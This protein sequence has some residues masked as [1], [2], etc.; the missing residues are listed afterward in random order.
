MRKIRF[1]GMFLWYFGYLLGSAVT[2]QTENINFVIPD[3]QVSEN[4]GAAGPYQYHP[5]IASNHKGD[6]LLA[7][8]DA[9]EVNPSIYAQRFSR[10]GLLTGKNFRISDDNTF[11]LKEHPV[12]AMDSSGNFVIIWLDFRSNYY[13]I[14]AQTYTFEGNPLGTNIKVTDF[15]VPPRQPDV[16]IDANGNFVITWL[17]RRNASWDIYAQRYNFNGVRLGGNFRVNEDITAPHD[18]PSIS[19]AANGDFVIT[20]L[21]SLNGT[22]GIYAQ[23][24]TTDG[25]PTGTNFKVNNDSINSP[26]IFPDVSLASNGEFIIVWRDNSNGSHVYGQRFERNGIRVGNNFKVNDNR[27][28]LGQHSRN[29]VAID[30]SG[31]FVVVWDRS[32]PGIFDS[33]IYAQRYLNDGTPSGNNF[34]VNDDQ[35]QKQQK[36]P[37]IAVDGKGSVT[38]AWEDNRTHDPDVYI[39]SYT[40]EGLLLAENIRIN[41]DSLSNAGQQH[42]A[43]AVDS[44]GNFIITW[45]D[46]RN[47]PA[48]LYAQRYTVEGIPIGVNFKVNQDTG[49]YEYGLPSMAADAAGNFTVAW[50]DREH[51]SD[52]WE[53]VYIRRFSS[54]GI[55]LGENVRIN[56]FDGK[57]D[58]KN[59]P[60]IAMDNEGNFV[61]TWNYRM[62]GTYH[63]EIYAQYFSKTGIPL[64]DNFVVN[65]D[66]IEAI[67]RSPEVAMNENGD[68]V[69]AWTDT[70]DNDIIN[71]YAQRFASGGISLGSN[72]KVS[73]DMEGLSHFF[74]NVAI[75]DVGDFVVSWYGSTGQE[76]NVFAQVY[77]NDGS[78]IG[79][80][81]QVND[82]AILLDPHRRSPGI[83]FH[84]NNQFLITWETR[85]EASDILGQRYT[86]DG[87]PIGNNFI[88]TI[89]NERKQL[90]TDIKIWNNRIYHTWQDN[91]TPATGADIWANILDFENPLGLTGNAPASFPAASKLSQNF[92]N[93][94]NASTI[95][96]YELHEKSVVE[97]VVYNLI[98]QKVKTLLEKSKQPPGVYQLRWDGR[99]SDGE[100]VTSGL[101]FYQLKTSSYVKTQKMLMIK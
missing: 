30:D 37:D 55:A 22:P 49:I 33:N 81:F 74:P 70:R 95:I 78:K 88:M 11:R 98:G 57:A 101:Y 24:Y 86:F 99:N 96:G 80:H 77:L 79:N 76:I 51:G 63:S 27:L 3:F 36:T 5:T 92:P 4:S 9:R 67:Q 94:F 59:P 61:V 69:I 90:S 53:D 47:G 73:E 26:D 18:A 39:Q 93:P 48:D 91:R 41:D 28:T 100:L 31:K 2:G 71:I 44:T 29:K 97:L 72:F 20:W 13:E 14:Y 68:F 54:E 21:G 16:T 58:L 62:L 40:V 65:D 34:Q 56:E 64:G 66:T 12:A 84:Q 23:M 75:K 35:S 60:S 17:D 85:F 25:S 6:L 87:I 10:N 45:Y 50:L 7:W 42:P 52:S 19:S 82:A 1:V 32:E 83:A 43:I 46:P 38:I 15:F 8:I 89:E